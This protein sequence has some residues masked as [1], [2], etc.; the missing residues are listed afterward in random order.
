MRACLTL[1]HIP[2]A[3]IREHR[4]L[5]MIFSCNPHKFNQN[6]ASQ[7]LSF[8]FV[9]CQFPRHEVSSFC[10][11]TL[12]QIRAAPGRHDHLSRSCRVL[13]SRLVQ[14][15]APLPFGNHEPVHRCRTGHRKCELRQAC[16]NVVVFAGR[17]PWRSALSLRVQVHRSLV[18]V[19][20]VPAG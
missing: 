15:G 13:P 14:N 18:P 4:I 20:L 8:C 7:D 1:S 19:S 3:A 2:T 5:P 12:C 17:A 11:L 6:S 16:R 9:P 10:R